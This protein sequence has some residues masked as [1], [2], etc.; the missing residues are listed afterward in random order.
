[1]TET[2]TR[3]GVLERATMILDAFDDAPGPLGLDDIAEITEL[4]RTTVFRLLTTLRDLGWVHH[5]RRGYTPGRRL[6][7]TSSEGEHLDLRAA[8]SVALNEL[9]L[10][11]DAVVHLSVLDGAI[12]HY[13]DKVGGARAT[14]IPSRVGGRIIATDSV[15]GLAMLAALPPEHVDALVGHL[16]RTPGGLESVHHELAAVRRR[17]GIAI[18]D[19]LPGT[20]ISSMATVIP[21]P[22]GPRPLAAISVVRRGH[23]PLPV[24]G[25]LLL[26]AAR[27][28]SRTLYPDWVPAK[29][30]AVLRLA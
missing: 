16:D 19:G 2:T 24:V 14:T 6:S 23:L 15:S 1:M 26:A 29:R 8:A 27:T 22:R 7:A 9:Q 4:P 28:T 18:L 21:G 12:V 30:S 10:A 13:L 25:P 5:D 3:L 20:G 17:K 11:T